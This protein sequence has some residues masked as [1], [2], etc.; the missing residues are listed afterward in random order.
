M[1]CLLA[2]LLLLSLV[3]AAPARP[4]VTRLLVKKGAHTLTLFAGERPV[5]TYRV[6]IGPGGPGH[7]THEGDKVTPAGHYH[8]ARAVPSQYHLFMR[9]DYPDAEDRARFAK[10]VAEGALPRGSTIGGDIGLHG[11]PPQAEYKSIHE[12]VDWTLGCIAVDD[13][14]IEQIAKVVPAGTAIDIED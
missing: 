6:A 3:T 14:E 10:L 11:A 1:R 4:H 12:T 7:K 2:L 9:I 8:I 13:D 5:R